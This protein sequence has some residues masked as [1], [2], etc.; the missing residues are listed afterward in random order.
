MKLDVLYEDNHLLAAV[1]PVG[2]PSQ[3]DATGAEDMLGYVKAYIGEKYH[4]PGAV[5]AGLVHRLDRPVGGLM[6]FA[7]TSKAAGRLSEQMR[8]GAWH[9]LYLAVTDGIPAAPE[10]LVTDYLR[11]DPRTNTVRIVSKNVPGAKEARLLYRV[12]GTADG[13]ALV[14]VTLLTGRTHQIR[15]QL[16]GM[17][18][19]LCGD[20]KYGKGFG[21][22]SPALWSWRLVCEHPVRREAL[23]LEAPPPEDGPWAPFRGAQNAQSEAL[24]D[25]MCI[26]SGNET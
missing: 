3:A 10:G 16:S 1:K 5:Y 25:W 11:K 14:A 15:V 4:K 7:R 23:R 9:K 19:P 26:H 18:T 24:W 21:N 17:G 2:I 22:A 13:R 6:L 20:H 8:T 12:L